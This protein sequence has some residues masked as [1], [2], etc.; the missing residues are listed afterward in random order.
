IKNYMMNTGDSD[1]NKT[2][3]FLEY[4]NEIYV[5]RDFYSRGKIIEMAK[6]KY[7][8]LHGNVN[9]KKELKDTIVSK[10]KQRIES[11]YR[12]RP[13]L[14]WAEIAARKI[15]AEIFEDKKQ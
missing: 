14:D 6:D 10:I 13:D 3:I 1:T 11:E 5:D 9:N 12:K 8:E 7:V 2:T 15:Y 4:M